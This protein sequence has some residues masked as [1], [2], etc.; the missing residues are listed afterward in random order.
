LL[1]GKLVSLRAV[2]KEDAEHIRDWLT[3]PD[4][5][6]MLGARPIPL[7]SIDPEKLPEMFRMREGRVLAILSKDKALV[8]LVAVGNFHEFNRTASIMV[9]V[10]DRSEWNRGY[11]TDTVR[12]VTAFAFQ[13]LNLNCLEAVIPEFNARALKMFAKVGYQI[14]GTLRSRFYGRGKYWNMVTTS[15]IREGWRPDIVDVQAPRQVGVQSPNAISTAQSASVPAPAPVSA[16][17]HE[18]PPDARPVPIGEVSPPTNG[19]SF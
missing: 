8:G 15:A 13:D 4:L 9:L 5:L 11:G 3:D 2:E 17:V 10:G 18:G 14:E 6:H 16:S 12:T 7:A 19:A 1:T